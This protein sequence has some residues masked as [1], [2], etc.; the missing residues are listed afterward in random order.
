MRAD[1]VLHWAGELATGTANA[2]DPSSEFGESCAAHRFE[3]ETGVVVLANGASAET[4]DENATPC[5]FDKFG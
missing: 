1:G 2:R 5:A 3:T 4:F